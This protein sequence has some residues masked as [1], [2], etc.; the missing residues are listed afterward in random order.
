MM[1]YKEKEEPELREEL[2]E[3]P[4]A[5]YRGSHSARH[6]GGEA[7]ALR[8]VYRFLRGLSGLW[9]AAGGRGYFADQPICRQ[10][11]HAGSHVLF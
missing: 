11:L 3:N 10:S 2:F 8:Q 9:P 5:A 7:G 4:G 6:P 1:F